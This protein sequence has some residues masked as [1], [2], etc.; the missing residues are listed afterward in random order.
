V[1]AD[2]EEKPIEQAVGTLSDEA[3]RG[4]DDTIAYMRELHR[5]TLDLMHDLQRGTVALM[6]ELHA[7]KMRAFD[8][9]EEQ[10][11]QKQRFPTARRRRK[12]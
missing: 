2:V 12:R 1:E 6:H 5:G 7:E 3:R 4:I 9:L 10:I 11:R 8:R